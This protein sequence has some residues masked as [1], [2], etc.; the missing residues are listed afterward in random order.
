M[1][2]DRIFIVRHGQSIGNVDR[3]VY[4]DIPDYSLHLTD[5]GKE[6]AIAVG[7]KIYSIIGDAPVH[8]YVSPFWRTRQTYLGIRKNIPS[9]KATFYEDPRIREQEWNQK[10]SSR[11]GYRT[12]EELERDNYGHFYYRFNGGESC[13]DVFD[14]VS[15]FLGTMFRDFEKK[16]FPKNVI[17][18]THG[19]TMRL[20]LMRWF[21]SSVEEFETWGNPSN[22]DYFLL[23]KDK[24]QKYTLKSPLRKHV[25][26][27]K[28]QFPLD[29]SKE[30]FDYPHVLPYEPKP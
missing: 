16:K 6:Q 26:R 2:P 20:I 7:K 28:F 13:A 3:E 30:Y 9:V 22:C 11:E 23:E 8:Y 24:N 4:K 25:I 27:H 21:H 19:M 15:D 5:T 10:L 1:K 29:D 12:N 18:V 14:R 17:I